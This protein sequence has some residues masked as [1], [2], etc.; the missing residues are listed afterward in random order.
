MTRSRPADRRNPRQPRAA[1]VNG[2][3]RDMLLPLRVVFPLPLICPCPDLRQ[4]RD[5]LDDL[6][7]VQPP[8]PRLLDVCAPVVVP[9][10]YCPKTRSWG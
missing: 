7:S 6:R 9:L 4:A 1:G 5:P 2:E 3:F 8:D 10:P